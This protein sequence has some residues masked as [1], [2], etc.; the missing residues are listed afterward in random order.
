MGV[1]VLTDLESHRHGLGIERAQ[2]DYGAL[3]A[4]SAFA[5]KTAAMKKTCQENL[6]MISPRNLTV[7]AQGYAVR[8]LG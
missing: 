6:I 3:P 1:G 4:A 5:G 2:L 8:L 7:A